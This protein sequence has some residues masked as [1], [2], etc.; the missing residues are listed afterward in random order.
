MDTPA[1]PLQHDPVVDALRD[2]SR[3]LNWDALRA[4]TQKAVK[5][6]LL[7]YL[8]CLIAGRALMGLPGWIAELAERGGRADAGI[9]GGAKVPAPIAA[10]ANGYY[11]H[12]LE[13]DDT[14][15]AAVLHAGAAAIPAALATAQYRATQDPK[16]LLE[17][18][19]LGIETTC[20]LGVATTLNLVDSGWIY[21]AVLG[22]FGAAA[23]SARL[24]EASDQAFGHAFGIVYSLA[25]GTHQS[26]R[27][28]T[29]TKHVQ[30]GFAA[31]NGVN[32]ALM[33]ANGLD[34]V[35][36]TF[37]GEDGLARVFLQGK[38]DSERVTRDLGTTFETER[39]S[40]K[41]YP[42]CRF[43][44]PVGSA[45]LALRARLGADAQRATE[46]EIEM[47]PQAWNVVGRP[48][49]MRIFPSAKVTAQFSAY[50]VAAVAWAY[51][52]V[53]PLHVFSEVPPTSA[54]RTWLERITCKPFAN[55]G[56]RD[57]GGAILTARGP[58][59][60]ETLTVT[61]AK[62]HPDNPFSDEEL[63][64]KFT[65]NVKLAG[66]DGARASTFANYVLALDKQRDLSLLYRELAA[67]VA[68]VHK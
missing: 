13:L 25:S 12:V 61:S 60:V 56:T 17:A 48:E 49:P 8:G 40:F 55:A 18:L 4:S 38:L 36:M 11:G 2:W 33:A 51:G 22:H 39:L 1:T 65:S 42:S 28:G 6:E 21:T 19:L 46:L 34:G 47:G 10:L 59:G 7:D 3:T 9:V 31:H 50:W 20:R 62:G 27:E 14:H 26:S 43:T 29:S 32:A 64:G 30:P 54:V 67:P 35:R 53:S 41:P 63:T 45:A 44:H 15:D 24:L 57:I 5:A 16:K 52:E 66:W 37:S 58:F 23:A 68:R